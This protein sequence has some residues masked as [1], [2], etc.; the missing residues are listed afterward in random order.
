MIRRTFTKLL[1]GATLATGLMGTSALAQDDPVRI[2]LVVK[3]LGIGFF[4]AAAK[5]AEEAAADLG[6]TEIIYTGPTDTTAEAQIQVINSLIAQGVDAI[7][8]SANDPD[9]LVPVLKKAMQRGI[10]VISWDS[11]V[12]PEGR[13]MHLNPSSNPLIGNMIIKLAADEL[14]DG[15]KVALLSATTTSTNQNI[16][17]DEMKKV[18]GDYPG[19]ELVA[20]VYGDDL[21]DKSYREAQGL[22]QKY[23]DLD[24]IIAPTSVGIVAAAQA[25]VDAGKVGQVNVTGLGLPSEMAGAIDSGASKSFAIWNP[26]DLGYSATMIAH[27]LASGDAT[28]EPGAEIPMGR[29]GSVTLDDDNAGAMADPFVYDSSNIDDFK[30][31]F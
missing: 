31:I 22:M 4:E 27:A 1:A 19:I 16:W 9:A 10:T 3:A 6:N 11:G 17:I 8:V 5:G 23:P 13:Q 24:A 30:S 15:G 26:I 29:M 12:A 7:A 20:T 18:M 14:P 28:A 21:A 25:V 2:A